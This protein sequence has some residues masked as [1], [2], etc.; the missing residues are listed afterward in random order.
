MLVGF[1]RKDFKLDW[2]SFPVTANQPQTQRLW[3]FSPRLRKSSCLWAGR[4]TFSCCTLCLYS[5]WQVWI[6][7]TVRT[8]SRVSL[9]NRVLTQQKRHYRGKWTV[10]TKPTM[11]WKPCLLYKV[12]THHRCH[13]AEAF[14]S[15][16]LIIV[17]HVFPSVHFWFSRNI[18]HSTKNTQKLQ[19]CL[20]C[21][22][23][24]V[25]GAISF[26]AKK[27]GGVI[28][29]DLKQYFERRQAKSCFIMLQEEV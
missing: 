29:A 14:H 6:G 21:M 15:F 12:S 4:L 18:L 28:V 20:Q 7:L 8:R 9:T 23:R 10:A 27:V 26:W 1:G 22:Q 25:I 13:W 17:T 11:H 16:P 19:S 2:S 3:T 5:S 24:G